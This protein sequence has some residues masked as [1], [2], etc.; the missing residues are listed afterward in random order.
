MSPE[1]I[2]KLTIGEARAIAE[3]A[4]EAL[5]MLR[6]LGLRD[7]AFGVGQAPRA[8]PQ[9]AAVPQPATDTASPYPCPGCGRKGPIA[10]TEK[11]AETEC[12]QCG[13]PMPLTGANGGLKT[14]KGIIALSAEERARRQALISAPAFDGEGNPI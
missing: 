10:P 14:N 12:L 3:R 2:D 13:N 11:G 9:L 7:V 8:Q 5:K 1:D 4:A 6:D